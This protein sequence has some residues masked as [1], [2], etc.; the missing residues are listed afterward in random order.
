MGTREELIA[1]DAAARVANAPLP[2]A[3][4]ILKFI[5]TIRA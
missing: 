2:L 5:E 4:K 3:R 1:R